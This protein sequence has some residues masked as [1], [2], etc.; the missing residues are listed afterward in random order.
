MCFCRW[1]TVSTSL[2][3][4]SSRVAELQLTGEQT[5]TLVHVPACAIIEQ[6][7]RSTCDAGTT[8]WTS[9]ITAKVRR[10]SVACWLS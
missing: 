10:G 3:V 1:Q 9:C 2:H 8:I 4:V 7:V 6:W 5:R